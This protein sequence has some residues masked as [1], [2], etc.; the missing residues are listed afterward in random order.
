MHEKILNIKKNLFKTSNK[1]RMLFS[2]VYKIKC[3][4]SMEK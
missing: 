1:H 2:N 3:Y 4:V